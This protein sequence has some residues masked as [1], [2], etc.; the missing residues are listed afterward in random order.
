MT[1]A[2]TD[3]MAKR[4]CFFRMESCGASRKLHAASQ[5]SDLFNTSNEDLLEVIREFRAY[6]TATMKL[7]MIDERHLPTFQNA[8]QVLEP[9]RSIPVPHRIESAVGRKLIAHAKL[10]K[11]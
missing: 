9:A 11:A 2:M 3:Q 10:G 6:I 7:A 5:K 1:C 4:E 8:A